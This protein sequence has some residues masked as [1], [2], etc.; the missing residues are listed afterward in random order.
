MDTKSS[1]KII[2]LKNQSRWKY[3]VQNSVRGARKSPLTDFSPKTSP[4][5]VR[6]ALQKVQKLAFPMSKQR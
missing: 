2:V 6:E 5:L 3:S 4:F 1:V